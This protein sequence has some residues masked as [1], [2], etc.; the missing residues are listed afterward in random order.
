[1]DAVIGI[2]VVSDTR[3]TGER[4][5]ASGPAIEDELRALGYTNIQRL[6]V[7]YEKDAIQA[8]I[9]EMAAK[10]QAVFT[11][12]GTGFGPRDV[13]PEATGEL[14]DRRADSIVEYLRL[15]GLEQ[16]PF[17]HLSRG[18]AGMIGPCFVLNLPGSPKAVRHGIQ[19]LA[20]LLGPILSNLRGAGCT[21][22]ESGLS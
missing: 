4:V 22:E 16:T 7:P 9:R 21:A 12:G 1:M 5:D 18:I 13:T 15:K 10:C 3:S 19:T 14:L 20:P 17:S 2:L 8:A 11:T 6:A